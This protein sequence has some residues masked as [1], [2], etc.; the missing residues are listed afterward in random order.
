M[1][2]EPLLPATEGLQSNSHVHFDADIDSSDDEDE[3]D[4]PDH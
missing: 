3:A 1:Q 2:L 4:L